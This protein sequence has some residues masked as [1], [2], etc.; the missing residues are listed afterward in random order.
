GSIGTLCKNT[1]PDNSKVRC[2]DVKM[3]PTDGLA[4]S[5]RL[6]DVTMLVRATGREELARLRL[7][8]Q[9][10]LQRSTNCVNPSIAFCLATSCARRSRSYVRL[11]I[12]FG[13]SGNTS[14]MLYYFLPVAF[15]FSV[16]FQVR[17]TIRMRP[18]T[19]SL[20]DSRQYATRLRTK[21]NDVFGISYVYR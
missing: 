4:S 8:A 10:A 17:D 9:P 12:P 1:P 3:K 15:E 21:F 2:D 20:S 7:N 19:R 6:D 14:S 18:T 16:L 5:R 11:C 13:L